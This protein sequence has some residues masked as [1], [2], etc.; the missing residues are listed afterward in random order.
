MTAAQASSNTSTQDNAAFPRTPEA[1]HQAG[2]EIRF[3]AGD[4]NF[5]LVDDAATFFA[6][7]SSDVI[8]GLLGQY[9]AFRTRIERLAGAISE[10]ADAVH[11]FIEGNFDERKMSAPRVPELF[12][13]KGAIG[14]LN[15]TYWSKALALTD[16]LDCMPQ[17]RRDE[18]HKTIREQSA[19]D[20]DEQT[21]R[22]TIAELLASR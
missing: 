12:D 2:G 11:Y 18:W 16:V 15:S 14:A 19:P 21:V 4:E 3:E 6:P 5:E 7:V 22:P 13:A 1:R 17:A 8:D 20:F 10:E 9:Q